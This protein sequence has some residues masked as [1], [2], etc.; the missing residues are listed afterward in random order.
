[1]TLICDSMTSIAVAEE[2]ALM[3]GTERNS[4]ITPE[5]EGM[6]NEI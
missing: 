4:N 2:K 3:I 1:M 6:I 5:K